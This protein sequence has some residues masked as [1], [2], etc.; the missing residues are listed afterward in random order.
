MT[1]DVLLFIICV[2]V[3][4]FM[5]FLGFFVGITRKLTEIHDQYDETIKGYENLVE[6]Y[7]RTIN[8]YKDI[9]SDYEKSM[10]GLA[11]TGRNK[12]E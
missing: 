12:H 2:A 10:R 3:L 5:F 4:L 7:R 9:V 8:E 6:R 1:E 11:R